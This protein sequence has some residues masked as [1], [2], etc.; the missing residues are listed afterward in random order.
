[1]T[2]V[3]LD[4]SYFFIN[5]FVIQAFFFLYAQKNFDHAYRNTC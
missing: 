2:Q 1:M 5:S 3:L 4:I